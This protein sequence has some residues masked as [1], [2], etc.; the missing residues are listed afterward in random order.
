MSEEQILEKPEK[1][2]KKHRKLRITL[3][4]VCCLVVAFFV[5]FRVYVSDFYHADSTALQQAEAAAGA[6]IAKTTPAENTTAYSPAGSSP[7]TGIIFYPG[8][9]VEAAAYEP[10]M[11]DL[12]ARG[13]LCVLCEMPSNIAFL[14]INA[15]K[16]VLPLYPSVEHWYLA[17][18]SMGGS[19]AGNFT[20]KN[21]GTFDGLILLASYT[22]DDQDGCVARALSI[23]GSAD[24]VINRENYEKNRENLPADTTELVIEGGNH[25]GFGAYGP[26]S[27]DGTASITPEDQQ[28]QTADAA[29]AWIEEAK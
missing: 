10:L 7:D 18:H 11:L 2:Q 16:D 28:H 4:V 13:Y 3:I 8:A 6:D 23:Y 1:Q 27:G 17:G 29:A 25:A 21:P 15:A 24:G 12:A 26:Q 9:K 20:S 22:V 14:D 5:G 19:A